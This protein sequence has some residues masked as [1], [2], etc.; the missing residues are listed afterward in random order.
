LLAEGVLYNCSAYV[1]RNEAGKWEAKGDCTEQG[2][3]N[4][5]LKNDVQCDAMI[6][7]KNKVRPDGTRPIKASIPFSSVYKKGFTALL[8]PEKPDLVRV[9]GKGAPEYLLKNCSH[10]LSEDSSSQH[11]TE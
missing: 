6:N 7:S 9:Y 1:E 5:F 2:L 8:H 4:F 3:I 11:L 10:F